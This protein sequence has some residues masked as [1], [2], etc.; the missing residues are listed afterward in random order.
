MDAAE[1]LKAPYKEA[2]A[3]YE[4]RKGV[5]L[6]EKVS[7]ETDHKPSGESAPQAKPKGTP[8]KGGFTAV[9]ASPLIVTPEADSDEEDD[10]QDEAAVAADL[11]GSQPSSVS[12]AKRQRGESGKHTDA[13]RSKKEKKEKAKEKPKE[14]EKDKDK[15]KRRKSGKA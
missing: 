3:E 14:K 8:A 9:K 13:D 6:E 11:G 10:S 5:P 12:P 7:S 2:L 4:K 15:R 1:K